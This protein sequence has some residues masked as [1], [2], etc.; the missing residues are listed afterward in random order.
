VK[1]E[2]GPMRPTD[3]RQA[4]EL[5]HRS[6]VD[7]FGDALPPE[8]WEGHGVTASVRRWRTTLAEPAPRRTLRLV[9]R[10]GRR[11]VGL[12]VRGP[13][14]ARLGLEVARPVEL[15]QVHVDPALHGSGV[16]QGL[17]DLCLAPGE[18]AQLWVWSGNERAIAFFRR[19]GFA[20]D[21]ASGVDEARSGLVEIRMV[22]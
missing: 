15:L 18:P 12:A 17:L 11:V 4:G 13:S 8:F 22:R 5:H 14:R 21:G 9:A 2:V 10:D 16:G 1:I 6:C 3:A 19:N 20:A 7:A